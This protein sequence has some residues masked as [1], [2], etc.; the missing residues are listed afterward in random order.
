MFSTLDRLWKAQVDGEN[1]AA[2][3]GN[4]NRKELAG[5]VVKFPALSLSAVR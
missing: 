5:E 3:I 4:K 2:M 1:S